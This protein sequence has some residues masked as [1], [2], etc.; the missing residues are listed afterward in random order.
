[1]ESF[2]DLFFSYGNLYI[3]TSGMGFVNISDRLV[4]E[5]PFPFPVSPPPL[6]LLIAIICKSVFPCYNEEN[7]ELCIF[8]QI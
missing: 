1:M 7:V 5:T 6:R 2:H 8:L 3:I 4:S